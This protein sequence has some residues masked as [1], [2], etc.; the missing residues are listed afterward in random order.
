[1]VAINE[2]K[3]SLVYDVPTAGRLLNLSRATAY[4]LANQGVIPTIRL[5]RRLVVPKIAIERMLAD[6]GDKTEVSPT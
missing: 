6:A 5:G 2:N 4:M 3:E 1:M